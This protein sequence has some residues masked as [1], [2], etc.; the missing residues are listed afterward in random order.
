MAGTRIPLSWLAVLAGLL[1][2][3][4]HAGESEQKTIFGYVEDVR[5]MELGREMRAK[6]DTGA[7]TSSIDARE[8]ES[9][10]QDGE[11]WVR[12]T[13][14]DRDTDERVELEEPV[15]RVVHIKR[16]GKPSQERYVVELD[17]CLG[18][19]RITEEVSLTSRKKWLYPLLVGRNHMAGEVLVD[20]E[21]KDTR[22][23]SCD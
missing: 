12:F 20:P 8:I 7:T 2:Q 15:T 6:L 17:L 9:F 5:V 3:P 4:V 11:D 22:A 23:P 14:V 16:H 13:V 21:V 1:I 10:E 18:D 19:R